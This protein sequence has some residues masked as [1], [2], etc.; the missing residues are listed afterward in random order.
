MRATGHARPHLFWRCA[1]GRLTSVNGGA[2]H[3]PAHSCSFQQLLRGPGILRLLKPGLPPGSE[4]LTPLTGGA[5][6]DRLQRTA[7]VWETDAASSL[8]TPPWRC[9]RCVFAR[10]RLDGRCGWLGGRD[11]QVPG[12]PLSMPTA[13]TTRSRLWPF[14]LWPPFRRGPIQ[15]FPPGSRLLTPV[16]GA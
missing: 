16:Y 7:S 9:V 12:V 5:R 4:T 1:L 10:I 2:C 13:T 14:V 8:R 3:P 11:Y 15:Y 6:T